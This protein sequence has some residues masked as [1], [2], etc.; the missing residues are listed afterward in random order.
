M[1]GDDDIH[2]DEEHE[3][4]TLGPGCSA[5]LTT[6][7]PHTEMSIAMRLVPPGGADGGRSTWSRTSSR[8]QGREGREQDQAEGW[9]V[10]AQLKNQHSLENDD[11]ANQSHVASVIIRDKR[12][13]QHQPTPRSRRGTTDEQREQASASGRRRSGAEAGD[14]EGDFSN[15]NRHH[16]IA[17]GQEGLGPRNKVR[18]EQMSPQERTHKSNLNPIMVS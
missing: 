1:D 13:Q 18:Y 5:P 15:G 14:G 10:G 17:G 11:E 12:R 7:L 4:V 2:D 6:V 3:Y 8:K 16:S 9:S